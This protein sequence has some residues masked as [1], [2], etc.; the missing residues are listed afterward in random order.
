MHDRSGGGDGASASHHPKTFVNRTENRMSNLLSTIFRDD[1]DFSTCRIE[2]E[3]EERELIRLAKRGDSDATERLLL[4]YAPA[5]RRAFAD[6]RR[7]V[8][9]D[10][11]WNTWEDA[12][13]EF[14]C[15]VLQQIQDFDFDKFDR[16][17]GVVRQ[18]A[19]GAQKELARQASQVEIPA[20]TLTRFFSILRAANGDAIH[21]RSLA[22][23][24]GMSEETFGT[25]LSTLRGRV[26]GE[27]DIFDFVSVP[28]PDFCYAID[29]EAL[30]QQALDAMTEEE[31]EVALYAFGFMT[32]ETL[33]DLAITEY[34]PISRA[35][36]QRRRASGLHHARLALGF[37]D[38]FDVYMS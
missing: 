15:A 16:L 37:R 10:T 32:Y 9:N 26:E 3:A 23:E 24:H 8:S 27:V 20:R 30:A 19:L 1:L 7:V 28:A 33:S 36:V 5:L 11:Y 17:A 18:F 21:A 22:P 35:T 38:D 29:N 13:S 12:Q 4:A 6:W 25:I 2:D 31:Q 34:L 14:I